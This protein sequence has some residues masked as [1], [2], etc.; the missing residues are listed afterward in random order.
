MKISKMKKDKIFSNKSAHTKPFEFNE[1]VAEVFDDMISRS[2]PLYDEQQRLIKN[3]A[4]HFFIERTNIYDLGCSTGTTLTNVCNEIKQPANFIGYDNSKPMLE[5]AEAK[6]KEH[7]LANS[8]EF[9]YADLNKQYSDIDLNNAGIVTM[10][11]TLQFIRPHLRSGL[12]QHIYNSLNRGGILIV[13]EK[14]LS[15]DSL[16]NSYFIELY[17]DYKKQM[18][19]STTEINRKREALENVL[20]PL[21]IDENINILKTSG[22]E[23]VDTFFQYYNFAAFL[24]IKSN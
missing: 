17:Y 12:I 1:E 14:V 4:K 5:K 6:I 13:T 15:N 24:C 3:I 20:V 16:L 7:S 2:V 22:F 10:L 19:Y 23:I 21:T 8:V 9:R 18:G 11:W